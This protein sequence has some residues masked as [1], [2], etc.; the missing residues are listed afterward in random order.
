MKKSAAASAWPRHLHLIGP[1]PA[2][3]T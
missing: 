2:G 3:K 1:E